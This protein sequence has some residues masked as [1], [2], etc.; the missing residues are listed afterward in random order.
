[1]K[2]TTVDDVTVKLEVLPVAEPEVLYSIEHL[3][4]L[5]EQQVL[6]KG[7]IYVVVHGERFVEDHV[8]DG[9]V[10]H[11][12]FL[13]T[14]DAVFVHFEDEFGFFGLSEEADAD[15]VPCFQLVDGAFHHRSW[16][17]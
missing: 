14:R 6:V 4:L 17:R 8:L 11:H 5:L 7:L 12:V 2:E 1:M 16:E 3:L 13:A 15:D 9:T 10:F